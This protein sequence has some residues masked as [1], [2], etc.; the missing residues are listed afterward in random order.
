[1]AV[2]AQEIGP[3]PVESAQAA[4]L[5]YVT[6]AIPGI[7]RVRHGDAFRY[8]DPRGD[9]VSDP[10]ERLRIKALGI[11]P[12]WTDVWICPNPRGHLQAT[13]RDAKGRKQYRYHATYRQVRDEAK[14]DRLLAF[15]EQ[16]PAIRR[17]MEQDLARD[18]LPREKVLAA[19]VKLL[20]E[21]LIR[22]GNDEYAR[23]NSSYGLTTLHDEHADISG[24]KLRFTFRGKSGKDHTITLQDRRLAAIVKR[25][26]DI[27][28]ERLFQYRSNGGDFHAVYSEEVNAYLR[29]ITG[30]DFSAKDFRTWFGTV[31]AAQALRGLELPT[32]QAQA[33][34]NVNQ[35]IDTVAERLGNTRAICRKCYVHPAV[36]DA[37]LE[38]RLEDELAATSS[39]EG[40][41]D[42][43]SATLGLLLAHRSA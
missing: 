12:A 4:G 39:S 1:M 37:Y 36:I 43:E 41:S 5:R 18:G 31:L 2:A 17:R 22:V 20:E 32:S 7:R 40:L 42:D 9:A 24:A 33:K 19:L 13:G 30:C 26:R 25:C 16:L 29:E 3:D 23:V 21:T 11:P 15:G 10:D 34:R 14:Y 38:G 27:P 28:G 6:D 8:L 35:A